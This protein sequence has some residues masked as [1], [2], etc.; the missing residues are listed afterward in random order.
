MDVVVI[1]SRVCLF[2]ITVVMDLWTSFLLSFGS[3]FRVKMC[4]RVVVIFV[5]ISFRFFDFSIF[6]VFCESRGTPIA[7]VRVSAIAVA[8]ILIEHGD[9][10][11]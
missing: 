11:G 6:R 1:Q 7:T 8:Q 2:W 5:G 3:W 10:G 9:G 4:V